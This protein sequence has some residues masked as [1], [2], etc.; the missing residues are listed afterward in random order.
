MGSGA[1]GDSNK[2]YYLFTKDLGLTMAFA[3]S[4]REAKSKLRGN[5]QDFSH[6]NVELIR[7]R[8]TWR[9]VSAEEENKFGNF[10][11]P[12]SKLNI[13][14]R[15]SDLLKR[16]LHGEEKNEKLFDL[17]RDGFTYVSKNSFDEEKLKDVELLLVAKVLHS[18]GYW[19]GNG[20]TLFLL[21]SPI[22]EESINKIS[23]IRP[24]I[25]KEV[26]RSL[27]ESHL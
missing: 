15:I 27:S 11:L 9:I 14:I 7:G 5:L 19:G 17:L 4:V 20:E 16:F 8:D 26:N 25:L 10:L 18:L 24:L 13:I 22:G 12:K 23:G 21:K 2:Y 6:I 3:Q 1:S